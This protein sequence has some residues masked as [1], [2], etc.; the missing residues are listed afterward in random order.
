MTTKE[1]R[2][3]ARPAGGREPGEAS[4][5]HAFYNDFPHAASMNLL[6]LLTE[7]TV[8]LWAFDAALIVGGLVLAWRFLT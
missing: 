1:S 6:R 2:P 3:L 5:S 7:C 8:I 4:A